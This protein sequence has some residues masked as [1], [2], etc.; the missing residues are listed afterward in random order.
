[1]EKIKIIENTNFDKKFIKMK[2]QNAKKN[3]TLLILTPLQ[4]STIT[5][6]AKFS[7]ISF[8]EKDVLKK[9]INIPTK[10]NHILRIYCNYG[11]IIS[12]LYVAEP[13]HK[14]SNRGRK[15]R[16]KIKKRKINGFGKFKGTCFASQITFEI[17]SF[18]KNARNLYKVKL[19]RNGKIQI[20]GGVKQD[21]SD[22]IPIVIYIH[23]FVKDKLQK[24]SK[25]LYIKKAMINYKCRLKNKDLR[26][27]ITD[28][29]KYII[30]KY[31][32]NINLKVN[33][34]LKS[35]NKGWATYIN[36]IL[37]QSNPSNMAELLYESPL[38]IKFYFPSEDKLL[39]KITV[40][41]LLSGKINIDGGNSELYDEYLYYVI[42]NI[43][44]K[45]FNKDQKHIN[46]EKFFIK[47]INYI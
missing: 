22:I 20:P 27:K 41:I 7:N 24:D 2:I 21:M 44:N 17:K 46:N 3:T 8:H 36:N 10:Y 35:L 25:I 6:C 11:E 4:L 23:N 43:L 32:Y 18:N 5:I 29:K 15:P 45:G 9:I 38:L 42:N 19:F 40:K 16:I 28:L 14:K 34:H 33:K 31:K 26:I 39:R 37:M 30:T 12:P 13:K 1:M 47:N